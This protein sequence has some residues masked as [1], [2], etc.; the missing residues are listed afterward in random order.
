VI[1]DVNQIA[2]EFGTD[3]WEDPT[4][5]E[6]S[7]QYPSSEA[8]PALA[9]RLTSLVRAILGMSSKCLV[10]DLDGVLWGG[11]IGEDGPAGIQLGGTSSGAAYAAFQAY[12]KGLQQRGVLLAV[13]SKNN[14][15]DAIL[16]FREHPEMVLKEEDIAVFLANWQPK[17]ENIQGIA[18]AINIGL[19]SLVFVDDNPAERERIRQQLPMV[20]V[21]E[22][23]ADP[24]RYAQALH[25][26]HCFE[27]L[28]FTEEDL[29]RT[30]S[31]RAN[32]Q[33]E[34]LGA[35]ETGSADYLHRLD[36]SLMAQSFNDT[37]LPRIVQL[38]NKTNQFNLTTRRITDAD[39]THWMH[40]PDW[41]T[42]TV[43]LKDRFGDFGL[44]GILVAVQEQDRLRIDSWLMSCRI[45]GRG[46]E[47]AMLA[48]TLTEA[49][50]RGCR[51]LTGE[52]ISTA[53]N[54][55]VQDLY[56]KSGF[57]ACL[58]APDGPSRYYSLAVESADIAIPP[59]LRAETP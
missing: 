6:I 21:V 23:P 2:A 49:R 51:E 48:M 19:D 5:W 12:C 45:L 32:T 9:R 53:K 11:V 26:L 40:A 52:Y 35:G 54:K 44:T 28:A 56:L 57:T 13:C 36:M 42:L 34:A 39:A 3:R 29:L 1:L 38:F 37:N 7:R 41:F 25:N 8:T 46:V 31:I 30:S 33:R 22:L 43:R 10:L 17:E 27:S 15:E 24:A 16:P 4:A 50:R 55:M 14:P 47:Q 59:Y 18:K 20:E 58:A